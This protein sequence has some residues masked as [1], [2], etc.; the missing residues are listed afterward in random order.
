M[1]NY[2][3]AYGVYILT[4]LILI[5]QTGICY[6]KS[7]WDIWWNYEGISGPQYWGVVNTDYVM[8][9]KG[10]QQ[11]PINIEPSRL[12]YDPNLKHL[13]INFTDVKGVLINTGRDISIEIQSTGYNHL[14]ISLGPLSYT[15][16]L[17]EIKFHF[18]NKDQIGSEHRI[19]GKSFPAEMHLLAFNSDLYQNGTSALKGVKGLAVIAV[20]IEIGKD[21]NKAFH[22]ISKELKRLRYRGERTMIHHLELEK[23]LPKTEHYMTYEGS[24][25]QPGCQE[26]VTWIVFNKP[27]KIAKEQLSA[28]RVLYDGRENNPDLAEEIN[29]RPVMPLNHRVVRT[30]INFRKRTRLCTM[31]K[32]MHYQVNSI[33]KK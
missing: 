17:E 18:A 23:L 12:L 1:R 15:Y 7:V 22:L 26:T 10:R 2:I 14:N 24:L 31:E 20:F 32:D 13:K 27:I 9:K 25:T 6:S 8:C 33:Y 5:L 29:S 3:I 30:N 21:I 11:S 28:L 19:N 16:R 4:G